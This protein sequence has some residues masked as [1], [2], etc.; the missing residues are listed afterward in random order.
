MLNNI[1]VKNH[2]EKPLEKY[3]Y[4]IICQPNISDVTKLLIADY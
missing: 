1:L 4:L 2:F 3:C